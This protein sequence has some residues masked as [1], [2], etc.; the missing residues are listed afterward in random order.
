MSG[1]DITC[2]HCDALLAAYASP[3]G[4]VSNGAWESSAPITEATPPAGMDEPAPATPIE[5]PTEVEAGSSAPRPLFD[6]N[7]TIEELREAADGEQDDTLLVMAEEQVD[8]KP[9]TF[10]GPDYA[11]PP[12]TAEPVPVMENVSEEMIARPAEPAK[13]AAAPDA[14]SENPP[15]LAKEDVAPARPVR[16]QPPTP[17]ERR[18]QAERGQTEEYLRRLH[19]VS[20]YESGSDHLSQPVDT[21]SRPTVQPVLNALSGDDTIRKSRQGCLGLLYI[22]LFFLWIGV[23]GGV[24][25]GDLRS[26]TIVLAVALSFVARLVHA[27][28]A[29]AGA[30]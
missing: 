2:P 18:A 1:S 21:R 23:I 16:K 25:D 15:S 8:P 27:I 11:K 19:A 4:S 9:V 22:V 5:I 14:T 3:A 13:A 30:R 17:E 12:S 29:N 10:D 24:M 28:P 26:G 7:V 6:T 20:G